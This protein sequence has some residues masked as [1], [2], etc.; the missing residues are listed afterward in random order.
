MFYDTVEENQNL[1]IEPGKPLEKTF[2]TVSNFISMI[3]GKPNHYYV[4]I[5]DNYNEVAED[6]LFHKEKTIPLGNAK[7]KEEVIQNLHY[8]IS[9]LIGNLEILP[10][11]DWVIG[12]YNTMDTFQYINQYLNSYEGIYNFY[13]GSVPLNWYSLYIINNLHFINP[14]DAVNDYQLLYDDIEKQIRKQLKKLSRLNEFL[15]VN[16]TIKFLLIDNKIK[17][18]NE[19]LENVKNS[20]INIKSLQFLESTEISVYVMSIEDIKKL[21]VQLEGIDSYGGNKTLL[22]F[23][24]SS[25]SKNENLLLRIGFG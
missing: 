14:E 8:C 19:E 17:I 3:K 9:Y 4:I 15:T 23:N 25:S 12:D 7:T 18:F 20:F 1:F 22:L 24:T 21:N 10:H 5:S 16:M 13:P 11:W 2:E 6:L